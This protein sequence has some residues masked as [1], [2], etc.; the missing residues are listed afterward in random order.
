MI[1]STLAPQQLHERTI[2]WLSYDHIRQRL[3][4]S[5]F[6]SAL[7]SSGRQSERESK[8]SIENLG[9]VSG[10]WK[11]SQLGGPTFRRQQAPLEGVAGSIGQRRPERI[12]RSVQEAS[13][14]PAAHDVS[15]CRERG[16]EIAETISGLVKIQDSAVTSR[17]SQDFGKHSGPHLQKTGID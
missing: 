12:G 14:C 5:G 9:L 7:G 6:N 13:Y 17:Y 2:R 8:P 1:V 3:A 16:S 11:Q 15:R 4:R 10:A